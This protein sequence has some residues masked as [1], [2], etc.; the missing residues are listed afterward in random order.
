MKRSKEV[1]VGYPKVSADF[2]PKLQRSSGCFKGVSTLKGINNALFQVPSSCQFQFPDVL[3]AEFRLDPEFRQR[4][5]GLERMLRV[6]NSLQTKKACAS[7]EDLNDSV[8]EVESGHGD[9]ASEPECNGSVF[10]VGSGPRCVSENDFHDAVSEPGSGQGDGSAYGVHRQLDVTVGE[11]VRNLHLRKTGFVESDSS[12]DRVW[13]SAAQMGVAGHEKSLILHAT[14]EERS[15]NISLLEAPESDPVMGATAVATAGESLRIIGLRERYESDFPSL[16]SSSFLSVDA[17]ASLP[18]VPGVS[19][20]VCPVSSF[21]AVSAALAHARSTP[22][23]DAHN[24]CSDT[25]MNSLRV[26]ALDELQPSRGC[27]S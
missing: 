26:P 27:S 21:S 1:F 14:A 10:E 25:T 15:G 24:S 4:V 6:C 11:R 2:N 8:S 3:E 13:S 20:R 16:N 7:E 19:A 22:M 23:H 18:A 5:V 9:C 17:C 12:T